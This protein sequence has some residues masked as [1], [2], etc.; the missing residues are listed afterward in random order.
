V[1][2][3]RKKRA[4]LTAN[5]TQPLIEGNDRRPAAAPFR[6]RRLGAVVTMGPLRPQS[7]CECGLAA[8]ARIS[9]F[10]RTSFGIDFN[11]MFFF[12][13]FAGKG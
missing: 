4:R 3:L 11:Q 6:I 5:G 1:Q 7:S 9:S 10:G 12:C 2:L 13:S 8:S